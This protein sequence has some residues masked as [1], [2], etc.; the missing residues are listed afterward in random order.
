MATGHREFED[1]T[2]HED[3]DADSWR[4]LY[5]RAY[6]AGMGSTLSSMDL[7]R[8][9]VLPGNSSAEIIKSRIIVH[10]G[11]T[12]NGARIAVVEAIELVPETG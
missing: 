5:R 7:E 8:G 6:L 11:K 1:K 12:G 2:Y 10:R 9:D 4:K 3:V